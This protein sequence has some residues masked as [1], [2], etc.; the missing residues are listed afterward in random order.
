MIEDPWKH[1]SENMTC[2]TC[3]FYVKKETTKA[4]QEI[5]RCR[6]SGPTMKG[7]P[8][9]FPTDWCGAHRIDEDKLLLG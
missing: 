9:V 1:K 8:V 2:K 7:F 6:L 5:G 3:M 4:A